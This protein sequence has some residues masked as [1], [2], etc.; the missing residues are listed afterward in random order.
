MASRSLKPTRS[1]KGAAGAELFLDK[2]YRKSVSDVLTLTTTG[3]ADSDLGY[4]D[5]TEGDPDIVNKFIPREVWIEAVT[6]A[7]TLA[8]SQISLRTAAAGG[9][10]DILTA[11]ANSGLTAAGKVKQL[12]VTAVTD[13]V[14]ADRVYIRQTTDSGNAGTVRVHIL[15]MDL[16]AY[17]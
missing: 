13:V 3:D 1:R 14:T 10:S 9:G 15:W 8:A 17:E 5:L 12:T 7:G 16:S 4:I 2:F 6:A 11:G